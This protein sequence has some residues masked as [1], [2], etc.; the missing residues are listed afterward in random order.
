MR[1]THLR[2]SS[3]FTTSAFRLVAKAPSKATKLSNP[4]KS[5]PKTSIPSKP[6]KPTPSAPG[7]YASFADTL[8]AKPNPT[9]LY[10][11]PSHTLYIVSAY[12]SSAFCLS[13][14]AYNY[15]SHVAYPP[16][17]LAPWIP[18]AF[19]GICFLMAGF[20]G[21]MLLAPARLVR[22]ITA[23]PIASATKHGAPGLELK[24][25]LRKMFPLPGMPPRILTARPGDLTLDSP[26]Y[27]PPPRAPTALEKLQLLRKAEEA[28]RVEREASLLLAPFRHASQA[29]YKGMKG[30]QRTW[31]RE[32][33]LKLGVKGQVYKLDVTGGWAA[34]EGR[35]LD[36]LCKIKPQ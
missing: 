20:G 32:G 10:L 21:W 7:T 8:A 26:V 5:H 23:I 22:T 14:S 19:G 30:F 28:Q 17:G 11:A 33:F 4:L 15:Y 12:L 13:Y 24:V 35:A 16:A 27:Y 18:Y 9:P 1:I 36:R 6:L 25:E 31:S 29:V 34:E 2:P 3:P